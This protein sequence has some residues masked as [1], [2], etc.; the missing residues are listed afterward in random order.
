MHKTF[1]FDF[2]AVTW[3]FSSWLPLQ[4]IKQRYVDGKPCKQR[5]KRR[6]CSEIQW[7]SRNKSLWNLTT[8]NTVFRCIH[9]K[10]RALSSILLLSYDT[11][12]PS[13]LL[14]RLKPWHVDGKSHAKKET[15]KNM[16]RN[17]G[18]FQNKKNHVALLTQNNS[19]LMHYRVCHCVGSNTCCW[20]VSCKES[21]KHVQK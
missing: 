20:K 5:K 14:W 19:F 8:V 13:L 7:F 3:T 2:I 15:T 11:F 6:I 10:H 18:T 1:R 21:E 17:T 16:F 4:Q 12:S 9:I